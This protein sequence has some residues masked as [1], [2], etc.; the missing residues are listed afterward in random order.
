MR[1][2]KLKTISMIR[3]P[4]SYHFQ[5]CSGIE[6]AARFNGLQVV[7]DLRIPDHQVGVTNGSV[8]EQAA[9]AA[10]EAKADVVFMCSFIFNQ[11]YIMDVFRN[12]SYAPKAIFSSS[13]YANFA[14][15]SLMEFVSTF[16]TV[17]ILS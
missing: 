10:I 15:R 4:D 14:D 1:L 9:R 6:D 8:V 11:E 7:Q 5:V 2:N 13:F 17:R 12:N 16:G 3:S